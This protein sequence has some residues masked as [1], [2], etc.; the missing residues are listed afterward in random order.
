VR[1]AA[2]TIVTSNIT[3]GQLASATGTLIRIHNIPAP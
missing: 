3:S 1:G 2:R